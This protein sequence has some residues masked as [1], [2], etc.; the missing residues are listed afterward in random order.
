MKKQ[1]A[2]VDKQTASVDKLLSK[3]TVEKLDAALTKGN[4]D[5]L[6]KHMEK[7]FT[8]KNIFNM[9]DDHLVELAECI[10]DLAQADNRIECGCYM[11]QYA[12]N[13]ISRY[14]KRK[15]KIIMT[16]QWEKASKNMDKVHIM[17]LQYR[18]WVYESGFEYSKFQMYTMLCNIIQDIEKYEKEGT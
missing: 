16:N 5:M 13:R 7:L 12:Q 9:H 3:Q 4:I 1:R 6:K 10:V 11:K 17:D 2:S 15:K 14:Q 18:Q 8:F